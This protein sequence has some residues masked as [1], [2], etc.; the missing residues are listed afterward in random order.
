M[1]CVCVFCDLFVRV[2]VFSF[3]SF[4]LFFVCLRC[5]QFVALLFV[6]VCDIVLCFVVVLF[7]VFVFFNMCFFDVCVFAIV[8]LF[9]AC[10]LRFRRFLRCLRS[11][12]LCVGVIFIL[13]RVA[14]FALLYFLCV[15][16]VRF[17]F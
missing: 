10:F 7:C 4:L 17:A 9:V 13:R 11:F 1:Q 6:W 12:L 2:Y 15:C 16:D 8:F 14:G 3:V 5:L